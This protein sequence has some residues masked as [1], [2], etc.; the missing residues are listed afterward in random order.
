VSSKVSEH[1]AKIEKYKELLKGVKENREKVMKD[2][3]LVVSTKA[4]ERI[5]E[6]SRLEGENTVSMLER[7]TALI[8]SA[9]ICFMMD[10]T[11]SMRS[12]IKTA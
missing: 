5:N 1:E 12:W 11:G 6:E 2:F 10:C 8:A 3:T 7:Q 4:A 9:D